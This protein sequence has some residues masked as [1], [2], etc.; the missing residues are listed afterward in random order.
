MIENTDLQKALAHYF[1]YSE[2]L[3][4]ELV[5]SLWGGYGEIVRYLNPESEANTNLHRCIAKIVNLHKQD[6]H[7]KGWNTNISHQRKLSSYLNEQH[8]YTYFASLTNDK[9]QVPKM[10]A[11]G[12]DEKSIWMILQDLDSAGFAQRSTQAS[13][14]LVR[15]GITWLANFHACFVV[16]TSASQQT[17]SED[18][19]QTY[20]NKLWPVGTYW[21]L[22][23]R[24]Q[25]WQ[26][27]P[28]SPLKNAAS[29]IDR[30]LNKAEFQTIVHG[31]AKLANFCIHN[32]KPML[33]ALDF[34]Y[35]G[36]GIGVKDIAYFLGSCLDSEALY[37]HTPSL[38]DQYFREFNEATEK[39]S[40]DFD[41]LEKEYRSL[42]PFAW[43]DFERFLTGW[44]PGHQK[45]NEYSAEQTQ[46]A[47]REL[48]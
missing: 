34:Q 11:A 14:P 28:E 35:V 13:L 7:P 3:E 48:S 15:L 47:L 38:L 4:S 36:R 10:H 46:I 26:A 12:A 5:Q 31:D 27:M 29:E 21:H 43:A 23:T 16:D 20:I 9:C 22:A 37:M 1:G 30:R 42:Y 6:Q 39:S 32:D 2:R 24:P 8:F 17:F 33:A 18:K 44:S 40:L 25:E 19:F 45:L 41:G